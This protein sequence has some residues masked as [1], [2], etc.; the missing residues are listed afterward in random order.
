M[1]SNFDRSE[2]ESA[3]ATFSKAKCEWDNADGRWGKAREEI[4]RVSNKMREIIRRDISAENRKTAK[5]KLKEDSQ[6]IYEKESAARMDERKAYAAYIVASENVAKAGANLLFKAILDSKMQDTPPYHRKFKAFAESVFGVLG[7][8]LAVDTSGGLFVVYR[9]GI[10][11][12]NRADVCPIENGKIKLTE[13]ENPH[14]VATYDEIVEE[15]KRAALYADKVTKAVE[16]LC[17][18]EN[19]E[20]K[21]Y[22]TGARR[23][24]PSMVCTP[25][26]L[27]Y[28]F[29]RAAF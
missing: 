2:L 27:N 18:Q 1:D 28:D 25:V 24:L 16:D 21:T 9:M 20:Y 22:Q 3:L 6:P 13:E 17:A 29:T 19:D 26:N 8:N 12:Y 14:Y 5:K 7:E 11:D 4:A 15:V 23:L 10:Y